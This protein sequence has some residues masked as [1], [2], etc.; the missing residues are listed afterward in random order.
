MLW[1]HS[2]FPTP[3]PNNTATKTKWAIRYLYSVSSVLFN[4]EILFHS[5]AWCQVNR[6]DLSSDLIC[7]FQEFWQNISIS[8]I[9]LQ[10]RISRAG[11]LCQLFQGLFWA[12]EFT[13]VCAL[14]SLSSLRFQWSIGYLMWHKYI[15]S[16]NYLLSTSAF[17]YH[18]QFYHLHDVRW[19]LYQCCHFF[20]SSSTC[21]T[22]LLSS[23]RPGMDFFLG[24]CRIFNQYLEFLFYW[25]IFSQSSFPSSCHL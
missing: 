2:G 17:I 9:F 19:R 1:S 14:I 22:L 5:F 24:F 11:H 25:L 18:C 8:L 13:P 23:P 16:W 12:C 15:S 7:L 6:S 3:N 21:N 10:I 20:S 4:T